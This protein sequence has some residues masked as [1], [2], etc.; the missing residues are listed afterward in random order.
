M[1]PVTGSSGL[2]NDGISK[3]EGD[4]PYGTA[5]GEEESKRSKVAAI[6]AAENNSTPT[7][8]RPTEQLD[9][10]NAP[11]ST[12]PEDDFPEGGR[13]AWLVVLGATLALY[14][15]FG[16][17]VSIGTLQ[18]YWSENQLRDYTARDIGWIPSVFVYLALSLGIWV[19]P[20]FDR[21]GPKY[22]ALFGS[23]GYVVMAFLLA[24]CKLY[25]QLLLCCG[26]LGGITGATLTTTS[27]AVVAHWFK[28]RRGLAQG[29]AMAGSSFGG[30]TIPLILR[31]TLRKYGYSWS[32]RMLGFLFLA[33]LIPANILMKA[34]IPPSPAVKNKSIISPSIFGDL[35]F[36]LLTLSVFGFEIVLFGS[37][38]ILPTYASLATNYPKDTGFYLIS[39]M[40]GVSCLGR[41]IPGYISDKIGRFNT[42]LIF[43]FTTLIFML[44]LWLPLGTKSLPTLYI[45]AALFGFGTGCWMAL[46]PA[47]IGQLCRAEEFGRY[48][49]TL[50][51][52]ASLATLVCI[53]IS[54]ELIQVVGAQAMVGFF[55]AV[56]GLALFSFAASRWACLGW[57]WKWMVKI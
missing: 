16:F 14:G 56:L 11:V 20:L 55:C 46:T 21:Y 35:R 44:A 30:L 25:W 29:I 32:I 13:E 49:G 18:D 36:S 23:I 26:F 43:I 17:M 52:I 22:I 2:G 39:T 27:L 12:A 9:I 41:L 5:E 50:Y 19:G 38:G 31:A 40:N 51:F 57:R 10:E 37:L 34:R 7:S 48:Y 47:C 8:R 28:S 1:D 15:S 45:F 42:L 24:E 53:P 6:E 3:H 33:T 4:G 54:G